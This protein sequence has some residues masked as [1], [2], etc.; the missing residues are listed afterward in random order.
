MKTLDLDGALSVLEGVTAPRVA[1][2]VTELI[3]LVL[4]ATA[5]GAR[6]GELVVVERARGEPV[7]AEVVGFHDE[8]VVLLPLGTAE[9]IGPDSVVRPTGR[10]F[11]IRC[12]PQLLGRVINAMGEP[13]DGGEPLPGES[14]MAWWPV[15]RPAPDPLRR[16][17]V[18]RPLSLGLRALDSVL[19]LGEGQRIGLFAGPGIG[20]STLLGQIAR[21]SDAEVIVIGLVG[22]RGREVRDFLE[23]QLDEESRKRAVCVCATSDAPPLLR[24]KSALVAT[25]VAEYFRERGKRVLLLVDSLTR[26]AR[27]Q[28]EV[29]LA[30]GEPPA[31][32]GYPPSVF[33]MLPQLLE[34]SGQSAE[35]SITAVYAVL[36]A[37]DDTDDPI[38][39]EVRAILD[40]HIV[41]SRELAARNHW[42]AIDVV[43]SLSR[44]MD[45]LVDPAHREAAA[46]LRQVLATYE[47]Q[48]DLVLLGAYRAGSDPATDDA[49]A[50]V[51]DVEAFLRQ[52]RDERIAFDDARRQLIE[53]FDD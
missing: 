48:R 16:R 45:D 32:Q 24:L 5:P 21:N 3:G 42:P 34:R 43:R 7:K 52:R 33:A 36:T 6:V 44:V 37:A 46:R 27:A 39:D 23:T 38:A 25:A 4:R 18:T 35:G 41:L 49:L 14:A 10:S 28:R 53:L 51:G 47:R 17:R 22:E 1:G 15:E 31:R 2:R 8:Q 19:T 29:G 20:K 30:A 13:I 9:G 26:V 40:G 11:S 12:G 50:R